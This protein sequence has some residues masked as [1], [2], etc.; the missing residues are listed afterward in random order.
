MGYIIGIQTVI[1]S[2]SQYMVAPRVGHLERKKQM[3]DYLRHFKEATIC[4]Q[5]SKPDLSSYPM[6]DKNGYIVSMV[7]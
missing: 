1:M 4:V 7:M 6:V 3:Y 2:I 5:T